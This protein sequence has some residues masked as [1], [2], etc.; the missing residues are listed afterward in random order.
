[1]WIFPMENFTDVSVMSVTVFLTL[2]SRV[3]WAQAHY[4][5]R[6]FSSVYQNPLW[7]WINSC[8]ID[9]ISHDMLPDHSWLLFYHHP[10][11]CGVETSDLPNHGNGKSIGYELFS[12]QIMFPVHRHVFVSCKVLLWMIIIILINFLI[13]MFYGKSNMDN[14]II[15]FV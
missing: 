10:T 12:L 15:T 13:I 5:D 1:M 9:K 6:L 4:R 8:D 2:V 7:K 14:L 3:K 11:A